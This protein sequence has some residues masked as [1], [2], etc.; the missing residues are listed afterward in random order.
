ME[1]TGRFNVCYYPKCVDV[2][3]HL[4]PVRLRAKMMAQK[5]NSAW[6]SQSNWLPLT[7][8]EE[9]ICNDLM[10]CLSHDSLAASWCWATI[11]Y[12]KVMDKNTR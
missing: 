2:S 1:S 9:E 12:Y 8:L 10:L 6:R 3:A 7:F 11:T 5:E 4:T